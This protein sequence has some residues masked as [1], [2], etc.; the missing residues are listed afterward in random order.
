MFVRGG[1]INPGDPR[2]YV[3][4]RGYYWS[5]VGNN[6]YVAYVLYFDSGFVSPSDYFSRYF[7]QSLRCVALGG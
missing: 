7:G 6:S 4:V 3:G 1:L 5:S 2:S